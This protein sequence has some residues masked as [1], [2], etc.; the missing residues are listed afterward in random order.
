MKYRHKK[1]KKNKNKKFQQIY[2]YAIHQGK[3][4]HVGGWSNPKK[5][6]CKKPKKG[7]SRREKTKEPWGKECLF[8]GDECYESNLF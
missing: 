8:R 6:T 2:L 7:T 1:Q 5:T 4:I 3:L